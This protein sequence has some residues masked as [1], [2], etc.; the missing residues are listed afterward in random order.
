M[1]KNKVENMDDFIGSEFPTPKGG[2]L[3]VVGISKRKSGGKRVYKTSCSLCSV[4]TDLYPDGFESTKSTL[5]K[6]YCSCGCISGFRYTERQQLIRI[7]R[8]CKNRG[9]QFNGFVGE[10]TGANFTKLK[11]V[12]LRDGNT[13]D[14]T[15]LTRFFSGTGCIDCALHFNAIKARTDD[16][17]M[18]K[19]FQEKG[20]YPEG[21]L[22]T[23]NLNLRSNKNRSDYWSINC[24]I[25]SS[26]KYVLAGV[27]SGIFNQTS[28][29]IKRGRLRCR[30]AANYRWSVEEREF[31]IVTECERNNFTWLGW[32]EPYSGCGTRFDWLCELG[33]HNISTINSF[34]SA[35]SRCIEC[36]G[37]IKNY[38]YVNLIYDGVL[39]IG[40]KYGVTGHYDERVNSQNRHSIYNITK[41]KLYKYDSHEDCLAAELELKR[42]YPPLCTKREVSDGYTETT[43]ITN[44]EHIISVYERYNGIEVSIT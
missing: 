17:L 42:L 31:D 18:I 26:D 40:I 33:H 14:T 21:T 1:N 23:R 35:G 24:P 7:H 22:C 28:N 3:T 30:C 13:W 4:D 9:Y 16:D 34:L 29:E 6:G 10:Y 44:F 38:S 11:L 37:G 41:F 39:P 25:C 32:I 27:C 5:L 43:F 36:N 19:D 2:V 12:C 8:E 15:S 20:S